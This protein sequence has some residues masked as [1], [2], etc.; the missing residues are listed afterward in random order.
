MEL[1]VRVNCGHAYT[2]TFTVNFCIVMTEPFGCY[3]CTV[4]EFD[5]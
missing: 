1:K 5:I 3:K 4:Y 2:L